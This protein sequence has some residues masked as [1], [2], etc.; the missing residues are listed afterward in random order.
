MKKLTWLVLTIVL[1]GS[2][3]VSVGCSST[4]VTSSTTSD[5]AQTA[6]TTQAAVSDT[7]SAAGATTAATTAQDT[8][9][10]VT[11]ETT[12]TLDELKAYDGQNG[13]LAYV[14]IEGV[15]YD[16]TNIKEWKAGQHQGLTA[17]NDLTADLA[18]SP[19]GTTVLGNLT[20][21]GTLVS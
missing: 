12:F 9:A 11:A 21:V 8:T 1:V 18:A 4:K 5:T 2:M 20:Q 13:N 17:G 16:V 10:A 3:V 15:V 7:T 14:A 19:H 6:A